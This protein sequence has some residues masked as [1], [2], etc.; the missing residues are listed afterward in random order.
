MKRGLAG[1]LVLLLGFGSGAGLAL[2]RAGLF[3]AHRILPG[4]SIEDLAVGGLTEAEAADI[5]RQRADRLLTRPLT[6]RLGADEVTLTAAELGLRLHVDEAARQARQV[7]RTGSWWQRAR[8]L[9]DL[10]SVGRRVPLRASIDRRALRR[11]VAGLAAELAPRP[12]DARVTVERGVVVIVQP[13][14]PGLTLDVEATVREIAWAIGSGAGEAEAVVAVADPDFTTAE[15]RELRAPLARY[16]TLVAGDANRMHN[17]ALAAG[18]I[19]GQI[20][21]PGETFSYNAAVGPRTAERGFREAPVLIDDELVPGDGGGVCQVSST[22]FNVALLADFAIESRA[23][24][25]RPVAYL[26][27]GRDATVVYGQVDLRF[28]N[29]SGGHVLL[30]AELVGRQLTITA[31]GTPEEGKEVEVVVTDR[32]V[33]APPKGTVRKY[34]ARL[35]AGTVVAHDAQPGYRLTTWRIVTVDGRVVRRD[36]IGQS[37]YRPVPHTIRIGTRRTRQLG[38]A[39]GAAIRAQS[40]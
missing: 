32:H 10:V 36:V 8:T 35:D 19:R 29:T 1:L 3:D 11:L 18:A 21:A 34:D 7:G 37:V 6:L 33:L 31:F 22:L 17:V 28:R 16:S 14:R 4:V 2:A 30:W 39:P 40:P 27:M 9:A 25:S 5:L 15:A 24:H 20:L 12:Q 13:G 38:A 23:S 26:P